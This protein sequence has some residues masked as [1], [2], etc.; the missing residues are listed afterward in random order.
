MEKQVSEEVAFED[1]K[2]YLKKHL[3]KEFRRGQMSD[4]KIKEEYFDLIEAV[5][6]GLLT[7]DDKGKAVYRLRDPLYTDKENKDLAITEIQIRNR[8][9]AADK[10]LLM[11]GINPQKQ[12]GTYTVKIISYITQMDIRDVKELSKDD[13]DVLNALCSV[14]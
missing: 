7:L 4:D 10:N 13:F 11:D 1:V 9:R 2:S 12:L 14:F 3:R 6:D 8:V 5:Q